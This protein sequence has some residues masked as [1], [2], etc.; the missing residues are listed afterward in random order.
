MGELP[1]IRLTDGFQVVSYEN[2]FA[3]GLSDASLAYLLM[4]A[5]EDTVSLQKTVSCDV[6][7]FGDVPW[8]QQQSITKHQAISLD[9]DTTKKMYKICADNLAKGIMVGKNG[10]I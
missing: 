3:S 4:L 1:K 5:G 2:Y 6:S 7:V 9:S 8:S 10:P